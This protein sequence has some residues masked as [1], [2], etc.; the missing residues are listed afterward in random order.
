M[1]DNK[2]CPHCK[3]HDLDPHCANTCGWRIC[4]DC[5]AV[6]GN[7]RWWRLVTDPSSPAHT[8]TIGGDL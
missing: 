4:R 2:P 1:P 7:R 3:S 6:I 5:H 8:R